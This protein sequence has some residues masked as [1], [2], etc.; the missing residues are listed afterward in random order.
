M[1]AL[2]TPVGAQRPY[3]P[4]ALP[5]GY[6]AADPLHDEGTPTMPQA[7]S[8]ASPV[9]LV[10]DDEPELRSLLVEYLGRHGFAVRAAP[11]AAQAREMVLAAAPDLALLDVNMPGENGLSLA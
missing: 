4:A 9:V 1:P 8:N 10:V 11:N 6:D 5:A 7:D 2:A 3:F